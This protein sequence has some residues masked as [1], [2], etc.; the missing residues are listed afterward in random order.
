MIKKKKKGT[1]GTGEVVF[2]VI[3]T[4][5]LSFFMAM[6]IFKNDKIVK[7]KST[8]EELVYFLEQYENIINNYY[9]EVD[10]DN[11]ID[12]AIKGM[13]D[14]LEDP[15][16][17]YFD[18]EEA[19]NFNIKL[20]GT[21]EGL[22]IEIITGEDGEIY[23]YNVFKNSSAF[24]AGLKVDD[25]II[26]I[27]EL[28]A[29]SMTTAEFSSYVSNNNKFSLVIERNGEQL[30][31]ELNKSVIEIDSVTSDLI[32]QNDKKIGYLKLEIF[33]L[34]TFEQTKDELESL[35]K[36]DIDYLI[37]DLCDNSGGHLSSAENILSLF[38]NSD[39]VI[40]QIKQ[41]NKISQF[42]SSGNI[43]KDYKIVV[44]VNSSSASASEIV[45]AALRE[46]LGATIIG[47]KTYGKGTAQDLII[48]SSGEQY[49]FTTKEWLTSK[50]DSINGVG[51]NPDII[52]KNDE[53]YLQVALEFIG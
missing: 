34:N 33:A 14:S 20:D 47:N 28:D 21:Y 50:G 53:S 45:A 15:Y 37:I 6:L 27:N 26:S 29:S 39:K 40:Y 41:N 12:G 23:I 32:E 2:L 38:M 51:I 11:L 46:Q 36:N 31:F 10:K 13:I 4:C 7:Y 5:I 3:V 17:T 25:K 42:Y 52:I 48:L 8:D 19:R 35:E 24:S 9:G 44:L 49:K 16:S 43:D 22:G 18:E 1:F 30:E